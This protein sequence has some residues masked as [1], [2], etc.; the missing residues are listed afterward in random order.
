M[1]AGMADLCEIY[2][3]HPATLE[4]LEEV[5]DRFSQARGIVDFTLTRLLGNEARHVAPFLDRPWG[6]LLTPD[7][8]V[9]HFA[10]LFEVQ[11]EFLPMA[12]KVLPYFRA[13][14]PEL[15]E[16]SA[17]RELAWRVLKLLILVHLSPRRE[18]ARRGAGGPVAS[19]EGLEHRPEEKPGHRP[20]SA[21]DH[22]APGRLRQA[23]GRGLPAR[24]GGRQQGAPRPAAREDRRGDARA[25]RSRSSKRW[26][27]CCSI[28]EFNPF[29]QPRDRW[30]T[31]KVRWHF[32][33][34]D[35]HVY[36]GGGVPPDQKGLCLQ[37]G[38]PWGP[39]PEGPCF[40]IV[41]TPIE[42]GPDLLELAALQQLQERPLPARVLARIQQ[43]IADRTPVLRLA[44]P[45]R[46][47]RGEGARRGR[48]SPV[49]TA[50]SAAARRAGRP[51]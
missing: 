34:W 44:G 3:I 32:H 30:H 43:R 16:S 8:I 7:T 14:L 18:I 21:R 11:P 6:E 51:G 25:G 15:F 33:E 17:Q 45:Q 48:G 10:D 50:A 27:R 19:A 28:A 31:R 42:P 4:L 24:P 38:L 46:L 13:Q 37:I 47:R 1:R 35:L 26:C 41:P 20:E 5:R 40:R 49:D 22:R 9:D 36:F 12:Q 29:A 23:A 39:A 2:P